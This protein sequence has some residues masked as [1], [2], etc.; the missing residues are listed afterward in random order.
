MRRL[1]LLILTI[2]LAGCGSSNSG[3]G[4]NGNDGK[5]SDR[6]VDLNAKPPF[7]NSLDIDPD[8]GDFLLTTNKGFWRITQAGKVTQIKGAIEAEGKKDTVGTFLEFEA[9]GGRRLVGSGHPDNQNTLPQFLGF[10]ESEDMG[11]TWRVVSRLG[12][13]D[14]HKVVN[15]HD[16]LYAFDAV[17]GAMLISSDQGKTFEERFTPRGLV[18]DFV[19]DPEN[20]DYI[21]SST[22]EELFKTENGGERWQPLLSGTGIRLA[23]DKPGALYRADADGSVFTSSDKGESWQKVGSVE[24]EPYK[25]ETTDDPKHLYLAMS[26]GTIMETKDGGK[27]FEAAFTP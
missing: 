9:M 27:G 17:L 23:W 11:K 6:L 19:V 22:E 4:P 15:A 2:A 14:L 13:A 8:N 18:I 26:D 12:D 1:A 7:I 16:K 24:G 21:L 3:P 25:W 10:I 20:E 5:L